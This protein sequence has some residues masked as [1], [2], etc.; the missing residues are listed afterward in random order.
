MGD[1]QH[2]RSGVADGDQEPCPTECRWRRRLLC[3]LDF[4]RVGSEGLHV[5][6]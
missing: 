2:G 6:G 3:A 5:D 1:K 4:E